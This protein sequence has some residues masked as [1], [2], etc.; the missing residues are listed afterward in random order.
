MVGTSAAEGVCPIDSIP[1]Q[2][3]DEN[4]SRPGGKAQPDYFRAEI[5][6]HIAARLGRENLCLDSTESKERS[7]LQFMY[8]KLKPGASQIAEGDGQRYSLRE[9]FPPPVTSL[10]ARPSNGCRISS[11]WLDLAIERKPVPWVRAIV[12]WNERQFL[13]DQ[14]VL[15]GAKNVPPGMAK[16]LTNEELHHF[17]AEYGT[18]GPSRYSVPEIIEERV[19]PDILWLLRNTRGGVTGGSFQ[20]STFANMDEVVNKGWKG[21]RKIVL[22]LIDRCFASDGANLKYDNILDVA[23]LVPLD[24][25]K[26]AAGSLIRQPSREKIEEAIEW[27]NCS[28]YKMACRRKEKDFKQQHEELCAEYKNRCNWN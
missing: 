3:V 27:G 19:P 28:V 9:N 12:R 5:T 8:W 6:K 15:A 21:Y 17:L 2:I 25:Y 11:P 14:A 22:A 20:Y 24:E 16:P 13:A 4:G 18:S 7:L 10:D 23:D 26:I 1:V